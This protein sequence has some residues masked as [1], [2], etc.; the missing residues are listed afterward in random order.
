MLGGIM[1]SSSRFDNNKNQSELDTITWTVMFVI[2][3]SLLYYSTVL[4]LE[5]IAQTC[6]DR[7]CWNL[8]IYLGDGYVERHQHRKEQRQ[9]SSKEVEMSVNP[10][11]G[12]NG[13]KLE[14]VASNTTPA[15]ATTVSSLNASK[16]KGGHLRRK[17][18]RGKK[19]GPTPA[20]ATT[21]SSSNASKGKSG[22][23][24]RKLGRGKKGRGKEGTK[25]TL[26]AEPGEAVNSEEVTAANW[27]SHKDPKTNKTFYV[28]KNTNRS[29]W[30][31]HEAKKK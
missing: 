22:H 8:S 20:V 18:G 26:L 21:V 14:D 30:T 17:L 28:D 7:C 4:G 3:A 2:I 11:T 31:D 13:S 5:I 25:T 19:K 1:F 6:P 15:M 29:T 23:L 12:R 27:I 10:L 24:R 16:E 9:T